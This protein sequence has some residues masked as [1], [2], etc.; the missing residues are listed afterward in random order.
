VVLNLLVLNQILTL[1]D[2]I[3]TLLVL[4]LRHPVP[5]LLLVQKPLLPVL[6]LKSIPLMSILLLKPTIMDTA[7]AKPTK[8]KPTNLVKA[9]AVDGEVHPLNHPL[10]HPTQVD[11]PRATLNHPTQVDLP[12]AKPPKAKPPRANP[13]KANLLDG[14]RALAL[15]PMLP[16]ANPPVLK[17]G[18]VLAVLAK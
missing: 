2:Q 16:M 1:L 13:P 4:N 18:L 17:V 6:T 5:T 15:L 12:R 9:K 3:L 8:P 14:R 11:L 7:K 10:N